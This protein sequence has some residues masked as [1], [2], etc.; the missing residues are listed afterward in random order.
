MS[1]DRSATGP[2]HH[3]TWRG[4]V[5]N[6]PGVSPQRSNRAALVGGTLRCLLRLPLEQVTTRAIAA[7]SRANQASITYHFGSK[8]EL[9]TEAIVVGLERRFVEIQDGLAAAGALSPG[10]RM[11]LSARAMLAGR[12]QL[13][14]LFD[15]FLVAVTRARHDER[16]RATL[17]SAIGQKRSAVAALLGLGHDRAGRDTAALALAGFYGLLLQ[18]AVDPELALTS[19]RIDEAY[20]QLREAARDVRQPTPSTLLIGSIAK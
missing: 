2:F 16:V 13:R 17:G 19:E 14:R 11:R 15:N 18:E 8:E 6:D 9:V 12:R 20:S 5:D 4:R 7:E 3:W 1:S 10:E